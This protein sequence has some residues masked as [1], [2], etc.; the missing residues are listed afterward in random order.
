MAHLQTLNI[1]GHTLAAICLNPDASG[2]PVI[3]LHG[4][5]GTISVWQVNPAQ[6]LLDLGPCYALSLPGHYPAIAP[7]AFKNAPLTAEAVMQLLDQAIRQLVGEQPVTLMGHSTGGFA[8]LALAANRPEMARRVISISGFAHGRWTGILG[9]YQ[10]SMRLGW[11]GEVYVKTMFRLLNLHPLLYRWA[12]RFYAADQH[13]LYAYP[14]LAEAL[15][16]TYPNYQRLDL[17]ALLPYFKYMPHIDISAQLAR[18]QAQTLIVV[19][20]RDPIVPPAQSH[21]IAKL[22]PSAELAI[23]NGVRWTPLSR[24]QKY[25]S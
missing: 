14:D 19:G 12:M 18:I 22:I 16:R 11:P 1:E 2:E 8:A 15:T 13:A 21:Q 3:L 4:I 6:Y 9:S 20:D 25:H 23:I 24:H 7:A 5:T 10:R 17:D